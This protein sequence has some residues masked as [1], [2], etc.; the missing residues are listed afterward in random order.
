VS[1]PDSASR[2]PLDH[3]LPVQLAIADGPDV[4]GRVWLSRHSEFGSAPQTLPERL[5]V[6]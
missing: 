5:D 3:P 4:P 1:Q 2:T 6:A